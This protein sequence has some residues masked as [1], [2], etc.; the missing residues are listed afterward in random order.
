MSVEQPVRQKET[1]E[2][3]TAPIAERARERGGPP[4]PPSFEFE[5]EG[6]KLRKETPTTYYEEVVRIP[7]YGDAPNRC[8]PMKPVGF[9]E[10]GHTILGR[11]SCGTRYC[12]DH[13]RDW[14]E[15]AVISMVARLAAY[16][17]S[18]DGWEKRMCHVAASPPPQKRYGVRDLWNQRSDAYEALEAAGVRGGAVI[19]H[20]Y[21]TTGEGD[22]LYQQAE[23]SEEGIGKW[24][25]HR[26]L[27]QD[28]PGEDWEELGEYIEASPHY[29][30]LAGVKDVDGSAAPDGWVVENIRSF[31]RFEYDDSEGYEDMVRTAYYVLTH[32]AVQDGRATSTYF[33]EVHPNAFDPEE[34]LT[35]AKW[36]RIQMEA[37]RAVKGVAEEPEDEDEE[38]AHGPNECPRDGCE[39]CVVDVYH[40][41]E[42]LD[43]DDFVS[44]V[45][46]KRDGRKRLMRLRGL[47]AWW[48]TRTDRP[49]PG[50]LTNERRLL[51]WLEDQGA[52][53]TPEPAQV[54]LSAAVMGD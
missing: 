31:D 30:V 50:A 7:G 34:E 35:V 36:S 1:K 39:A 45:L 11:S 25:F 48:D 47:F 17:E 54:S 37:E 24:R 52:T 20:P 8:R 26:E 29:H 27:S 10:E 2:Q 40:L 5:P 46:S 38:V 23:A 3:V 16:R 4:D 41:P 43:D 19:T 49:P 32:G 33:G 14:L 53:L 51:E 6:G 42:Y 44:R 18:R 15:D 9:C 21:R 12:P 22:R 28:Q 13:W